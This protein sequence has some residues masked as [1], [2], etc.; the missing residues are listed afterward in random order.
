MAIDMTTVKQIMHNNKE[1]VKIEDGLGKVLWQ[2]VVDQPYRRLEYLTF[3]GTN[4][5]ETNEHNANNRA[6]GLDYTQTGW[7]S[8][9]LCYPFGIWTPEDPQ[10]ILLTRNERGNSR[11]GFETCRVSNTSFGTYA[12]EA[13]LNKRMSAE[14]RWGTDI[15]VYY[16]LR[17]K[18]SSSYIEDSSGYAYG[19]TDANNGNFFIGAINDGGGGSY[20]NANGMLIGKIY[21]LAVSSSNSFDYDYFYV[22]CQ[23]KSDGAIG[24]KNTNGDFYPLR[25]KSDGSVVTN[26]APHM[27]PVAEE[28]WDGVTYTYVPVVTPYRR[29]E[30]VGFDGTCFCNSTEHNADNRAY[31]LDYVQTG[32]NA[33]ELCYPFGIYTSA[34]PNHIM[35]PRNRKSYAETGFEVCIVNNTP[36][37][38]HATEAY[39]NKRMLAE[40]RWGTS[41]TVYYRLREQSSSTYIDN[42]SGNASGRTGT[43][44]GNFFIGAINDGGGGTYNNA[45]GML[46]GRIYEVAIAG[47]NSF[48]DYGYFYVPCQR[49]DDGA[50]G[51][52]QPHT[53]AF[54]PLL[55][56]SDG[57]IVTDVEALKGPVIEEN[58]DGVTYTSVDA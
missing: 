38:T 58:W 31:R 21:E 25:N 42:S 18:D 27:G 56:K 6:Y 51:F 16:R 7:I 36:F 35:L 22:P 32:W 34:T 48:D 15:T 9:G 10:N 1:I 33:S 20:S 23:R 43:N 57:S 19:R 3:D 46:V 44:R 54:Y 55:N 50:V 26:I 8:S 14:M 12:S 49:K 37:G 45:N 53:D 29:L 40:M 11:T 4:Y 47:S 30:Y 17:N 28:N 52:K 13:Y 5:C 39:L 24:F 2:K 41:T